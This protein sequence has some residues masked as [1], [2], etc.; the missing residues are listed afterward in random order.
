MLEKSLYHSHIVCYS[1][2][3][4]TYQV[5]DETQDITSG[6]RLVGMSHW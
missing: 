4:K 5:N 6:I 3:Q 2:I 1:C